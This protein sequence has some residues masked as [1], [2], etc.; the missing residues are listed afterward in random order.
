MADVQGIDPRRVRAAVF[1]LGGVFIAN[2]VR[3]VERFGLTLGNDLL[4][5]HSRRVGLLQ[6]REKEGNHARILAGRP[7]KG[8]GV[9]RYPRPRRGR[10]Q[11]EGR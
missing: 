6:G 11:G 7:R 4:P 1:D 3:N 2:S 9:L 5:F 8:K 10:G